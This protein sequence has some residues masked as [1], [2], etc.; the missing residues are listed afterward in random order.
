LDVKG[1]IQRIE[2]LGYKGYFSLEL[3]NEAL[4][5]KPSSKVS[6]AMYR[7]MAHLCG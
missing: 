1:I 5:R 2:E 3:F 4:W 6:S 7:A